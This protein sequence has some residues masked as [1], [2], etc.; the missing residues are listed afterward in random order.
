MDAAR[1]VRPLVASALAA[2]RPVAVSAAGVVA[3]ELLEP[4]DTYAQAITA[5]HD[6]VLGA[7]LHVHPAAARVVL[8]TDAAPGAAPGAAP[9]RLTAEGVRAER[10]VTLAR[11]DV[12]LGAA[13]E[14]LDLEL[15]E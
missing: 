7:V 15:L 4:N 1:G 11:R 10:L 8:R 3:V 9:Q 5:A 14:A 2:A 13:I 6:D 12:V